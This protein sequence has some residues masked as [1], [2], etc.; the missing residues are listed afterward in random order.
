MILMKCL[1]ITTSSLDYHLNILPL[2]LFRGQDNDS[3]YYSSGVNHD[4]GLFYPIP[5]STSPFNMKIVEENV[6][7][8]EYI[9]PT[10]IVKSSYHFIVPK[11]LSCMLLKSNWKWLIMLLN[12][13]V[14]VS[15]LSWNCQAILLI[16]VS[17]LLISR[18]MLINQFL[19]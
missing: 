17:S 13:Q 11:K 5:S 6:I 16:S 19:C 2:H 7:F 1:R 8:L 10:S 3:E 9:S 4:F 18:S 12:L 14:H 15:N